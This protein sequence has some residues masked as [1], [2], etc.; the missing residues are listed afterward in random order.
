MAQHIVPITNGKGSKEITDGIYGV[1]ANIIGYDN[2]SIDPKQ[3]NITAGVNTYNLTIAANGTLTLHVTDDGTDIGIPIEGATFYR[4]DASGN[5][6]G[7]MIETDVDGNAEFKFVPHDT[8]NPPTIYFIQTGSDGSH[9]FDP[10][11]QQTTMTGPTATVEIENPE[12]DLRNFNITDTN[13]ANLPV[14]DGQI[15]LVE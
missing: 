10:D 14:G 8:T 3:L 1:T 15:T 6:Y 2:T 13:Y 11:V 9:T 4:C 5:R 12:A 7:N